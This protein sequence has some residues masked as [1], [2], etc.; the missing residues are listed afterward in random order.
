MKNELLY[1]L[2]CIILIFTSCTTDENNDNTNL[3]LPK[4]ITSKDQTTTFTYEGNKIVSIS[5][6]STLTYFTYDGNQIVKEIRYSK[7]EGKETKYSEIVYTYL[8]GKLD[9]GMLTYNGSDDGEK[10]V[11]SYNEDDTIKKETYRSNK[12][13]GKQSENCI[14]DILT[15]KNGNLIKSV[16][17]WEDKPYITTCRYDYDANNNAFKNILGLNLLLDQADFDSELNFSSSNNINTF[18]V[19]TNLVPGTDPE[20][21]TIIFEPFR[22]TMNYEYNKKGYPTK[23]TTYDYTG[24]VKESIEYIY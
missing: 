9:T 14:T 5:S 2:T 4:T 6:K 12:K 23:K 8:N 15:F 22:D 11:Y 17:N 13:T 7:Y 18:N 21:A 1:F 16:S 19:F 24:N 20:L 3:I 10:Y